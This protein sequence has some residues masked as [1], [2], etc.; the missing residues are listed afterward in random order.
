ML[1]NNSPQTDHAKLDWLRE[2]V[3]E[4]IAD[5]D[6]GDYVTLRSGPEIDAC[7]DRLGDEALAEFAAEQKRA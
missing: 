1:A 7:I 4:G 3:K 2:A 6:R 5:I